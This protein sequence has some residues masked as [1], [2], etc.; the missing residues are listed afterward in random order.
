[1]QVRHTAFR[2]IVEEDPRYYQTP[3]GLAELA[4]CGNTST[5]ELR[6]KYLEPVL[7]AQNLAASRERLPEADWSMVK[8][9]DLT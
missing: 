5:Q 9:I 8:R 1:M 7:A 3:E 4:R 2:L 6:E